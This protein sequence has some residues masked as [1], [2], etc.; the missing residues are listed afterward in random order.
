MDHRRPGRPVHERR[1]EAGVQRPDQHRPPDRSQQPD[2]RLR[3]VP[4][5]KSW[6]AGSTSRRSTLAT[7]E[8]VKAAKRNIKKA[9]DAAK[10][11]RSIAHMPA[12]TK[13]AL[14]KQGAAVAARK[15]RGGTSPK[16]RAELYELAKKKDI[17]GRSK[18]GRDDLARAVGEK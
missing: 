17:A 8:Q 12:R 2:R 6:T 5:G 3:H 4:F 1:H 13:T 15:R 16:T 9:T 14:G 7:T 18:M 11:K 10:R